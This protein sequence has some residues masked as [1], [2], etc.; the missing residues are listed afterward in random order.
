MC[1]TYAWLVPQIKE[2][3]RQRLI[4]AKLRLGKLPRETFVRLYA[5]IGQGDYC[6]SCG[7]SIQNHETEY[8][9]V[10]SSAA[11]S[12]ASTQRLLH[13]HF[14]CYLVWSRLRTAYAEPGPHTVT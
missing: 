11:E 12:S 3:Q 10:F 14:D 1:G 6:D 8:Q 4:D 5:G 2:E 7:G 9:L 13:M